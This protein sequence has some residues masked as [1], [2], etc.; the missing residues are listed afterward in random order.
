VWLVEDAYL[1]FTEDPAEWKGTEITFEIADRA[2]QTEIRFTHLGLV[3]D[4]ECFDACSSAWGFYINVSL[5]SL[6][7][8]G[9]GHPN[10]TESRDAEGA[11]R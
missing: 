2:G 5:R 8:T 10:P 6:I 1:N 3:P 7:T 11:S 4:Y 9:T